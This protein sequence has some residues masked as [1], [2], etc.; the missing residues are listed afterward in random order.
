MKKFIKFGFFLLFLLI[1]FVGTLYTTRVITKEM[2]V[3]KVKLI[4]D[5]PTISDSIKKHQSDAIYIPY[6]LR[7]VLFNG[8]VYIY[9]IL[10]NIAHFWSLDNI[11]KIV[12]LAN[13]Y[14]I[15]LGL[16]QLINKQKK[17]FLILLFGLVVNSV[18]IGLN[19]M[20]DARGSTYLILPILIYFF[21]KGIGKVN[22]KIYLAM[23]F[24]NLM[25]FV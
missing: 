9:Q 22:L 7:L 12:L 16:K 2:T 1:I 8:S 19:K 10:R 14:P 25:L 23:L 3:D 21:I 13:L 18:V 4:F 24:L 6:K 17:L 5:M 15:I 20:V 11:N